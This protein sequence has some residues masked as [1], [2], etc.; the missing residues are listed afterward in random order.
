MCQIDPYEYGYANLWVEKARKA[1]KEHR[2]DVCLAFVENGE[3]YV[4]HT[5]T[6][7]GSVFSEKICLAC[8][9]K[10]ERFETA[11][12]ISLSPEGYWEFLNEC[13]E[14]DSGDTLEW[15]RDR[16]R[17]ARR[18]AKYFRIR[19]LM[20]FLPLVNSAEVTP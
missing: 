13:I 8:D 18:R 4:V 5:S 3:R 11:H 6:Y 19:K 9:E 20:L 16:F 7:D 1:R 17:I 2:C 10:R 15:R 12:D 14:E